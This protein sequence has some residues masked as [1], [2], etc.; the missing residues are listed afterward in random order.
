MCVLINSNL[1]KKNIVDN[2]TFSVISTCNITYD[3]R[4]RKKSANIII[5]LSSW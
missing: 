2:S 1:K 5:L 4:N 3:F